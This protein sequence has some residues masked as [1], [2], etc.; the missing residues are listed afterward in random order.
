[1]L[2]KHIVDNEAANSRQPLNYK[3][4]G[5]QVPKRG[6]RVTPRLARAFLKL[7]GWK[8]TG[9]IPDVPKAVLLALPHTSNLDGL[10]AIPVVLGLDLD[11]KIMGKDS[12]FKYPVL[13]NFLKWAGVVPINRSKKGSVLQASI[14]QMK[15]SDSLYLGLAPEGTRGFTKQWKTGFYYIADSADVPIIPVAMD[16]KTKEVQFL[17]PVCTTGN[18]EEDLTKIVAQYKGVVPKYPSKMSQVLQDINK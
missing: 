15:A 16:Y 8:V 17:D 2:N 18:Y 11:I 5:K 9:N 6:G 3:R 4:L 10:Y 1:M 7:L 12:L 14:E 13:S